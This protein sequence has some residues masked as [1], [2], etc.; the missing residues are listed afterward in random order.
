MVSA[1]A[2]DFIEMDFDW[3]KKMGK[4]ICSVP[5]ILVEPGDKKILFQSKQNYC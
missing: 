1:R 5:D 3:F 4:R 2:M